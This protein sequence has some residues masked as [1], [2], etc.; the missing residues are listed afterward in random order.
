[1]FYESLTAM[2]LRVGVCWDVTLCCGVCLCVVLTAVLLRIGVCWEVTLC[3][4]VWCVFVC[5]SDSGVAEGW[6]L[7]GCDALLWCVVC[8]VLSA[9]LLT[10]GVCWDVR[11]CCGICLCVVL[12]AVLLTVGVCWDVTLCCGVWCVFVCGSDSGFAKVWILLGCDTLLWC[13]VCVCVWF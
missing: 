12:S 10:V 3:C 1:M 13:V 7:L 4:G 5:G 8:V 11:L 6:N 2:L 9:M